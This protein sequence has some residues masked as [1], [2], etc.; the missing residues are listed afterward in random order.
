MG[1]F[2]KWKRKKQP[3]TKDKPFLKVPIRSLIDWNEPGGDGCLV[4]DK[5]TKEGWKVGYMFRDQPNPAFPDSGWSFFQGDEDEAYSEDE[6]NFH[7]LSLNTVCN[8]DPQIIPYLHRPVGSQL[9]RVKYGR[10]AE[11]DGKA[12]LV[13]EKQAAFAQMPQG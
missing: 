10:F 1:I 9:I 11:D 8:Y 12:V 3:K 6:T 2:S 7:V 4:S 13:M 5:I